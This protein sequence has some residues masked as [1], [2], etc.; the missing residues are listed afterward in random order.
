MK[1]LLIE[2][3]EHIISFLK[4]GF[5]EDGHTL[6]VA[7]D[8]SEGV[9]MLEQNSYDVAILDWMLPEIEGL[10]VLSRIRE[11]N[12]QTPVLMLTAKT[13]TRSIVSS[14][15]GGADDFLKK[16]FE[17]DELLA[18]IEALYRRNLSKGVNTIKIGDLAIDTDKKKVE[19]G[20]KLLELSNKEYSLLLF[21]IKHKK[22]YVSVSMIENELW[23]NEE[24]INSNV[25]NVTIYHLRKKIGKEMIK[26]MRG[27][28]YKIE[29]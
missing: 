4:R 27:V 11:K 29:A 7:L 25:I 21:L 8:G 10:E 9:Y 18:R 23:S 28:G 16:P 13:D 12:I 20:E 14:L 6:D 5:I 2:D 24:Y 15:N 3:D 1:L 17:Y 19:K 26:S 22:S